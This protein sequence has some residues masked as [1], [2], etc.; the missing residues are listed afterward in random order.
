MKRLLIV[1]VVLVATFA[2]VLPAT[3]A[4]FKFGGMF[5][6]KFYSVSNIKDGKDT[7]SNDPS[8]D[9]DDNLGAFFYTRMR[10]YF[11]AIASENLRAV[12]KMEVDANWG[13]GRIGRVSI[14][15]GSDGRG[16]AGN[17][18]GSANSGWEI[19]NAYIDFNAPVDMPLN[20]KVGLLGAKL[21]KAGV[22]FN[23]DTP[24]IYTTMKF[25]PVKVRLLYSRLND[26]VSGNT[27]LQAVVQSTPMTGNNSADDWNF[28]GADVGGGGENWSADLGI[29]YISKTDSPSDD[30]EDMEFGIIA[31]D[32][33][34]KSDQWGAYATGAMN[35]GKDDG[36]AGGDFKGFMFTAG[37][38]FNFDRFGIGGDFYYGSGREL[39]EDD[40]KQFE[41]IGS[42]GRPSYNMDD[43]VFPGWFD[44]Q[45]S[46]VSTASGDGNKFN[47]VTAT[48]RTASNQGYTLNNIWAIGLHGDFKPLD[49]T[50]LQFGAA[51]MGFAEDV[52]EEI[53]ADGTTK[54]GN[55]LGFST[56]LRLAQGITDGLTLK[57]TLGYLLPGDAYSTVS[58]E[59]N[60]YKFATGLFWSW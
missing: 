42:M 15:G 26:N 29:G 1:L 41:S 45:S 43:I 36:P 13:D 51:Y 34:Y 22:V 10:L 53:R 54:E 9:T 24:A 37:G 28:W 58:N 2:L 17:T 4:D 3:A 23:D 47:N 30:T 16:D 18:N 52:I 35:F 8:G 7:D 27:S 46:T 5:W 11:N 21:T 40:Q 57:A 20:F 31:L 25:N 49:K 50:F 56:Y 33:D 59:D 55:E 48:G 6:T 12:S 44:D 19:K 39:D 60:A 14:D 38:N 32:G